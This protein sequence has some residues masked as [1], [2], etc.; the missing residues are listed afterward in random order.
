MKRL[1]MIAYHVP[2]F[3]SSSGI[4]RT[5]TFAQELPRFG[6]EAV[7]LAPHVRAYEHVS[8]NQVMVGERLTV[9]R[10]FAV[11]A[12]R[13]L[14]V[15]GYYPRFAARPD[16]WISW[17]LGAVPKGLAMVRKY[18][19]Q[20]I[21]ST[22][23][24]ATAHRIGATLA[25]L[26]RLPWI[27][28]FRDPMAQVDYPRDPKVWRSFKRVEECVM[29]RAARSVFVTEGAAQMYRKRYAEVPEGRITVIENG[30]DEQSFAGLEVPAARR[31][32]SRRLLLLHSGIVYPSE[33]D[34][35]QLF[36]A[37]RRFS[38][39]DLIVRL[40]APGHE[41][42]LRRMIEAAGVQDVVELA[43]SV[44]YRQALE[45]M[46]RAD[47]LLVL[48][49]ANCNQQVPAKVY[50]YLRCGRPIL[51]LTD[52]AGDTAALLRRA[53]LSDIA[54]LD[55]AE[56]IARALAS[57]VAQLRADSARLPGAEFVARASRRQRT[58]ELAELLDAF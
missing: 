23:P 13:H 4:L 44:P 26:T 32:P 29:R 43:P 18:Q 24:I 36:Q 50:E 11:D 34:P 12:A 28:D 33:R 25:R 9:E 38:G 45:E 27:A 15:K 17:W 54:P 20:A 47:G 30:Y 7:V 49:A 53:G 3:A 10:A 5:L 42:L 1:L 48:Q 55:S 31:E 22:Y 46:C 37:L 21:W 14:A 51:A 8:S 19:P 57:F 58:A 35:R 2:P 6:W 39:R 16:R 41:A 52:P 56:E 40:R